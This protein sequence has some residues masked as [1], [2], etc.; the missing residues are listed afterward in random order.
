LKPLGIKHVDMPASPD[1]LWQRIQEARSKAVSGNG[2]K[3][4]AA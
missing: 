1:R 2:S 3:G 4:G